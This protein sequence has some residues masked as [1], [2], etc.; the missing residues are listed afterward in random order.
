M[1]ASVIPPLEVIRGRFLTPIA[2]IPTQA[3]SDLNFS[4]REDT[5][6]LLILHLI[7]L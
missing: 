2:R 7:S 5:G 1:A 3:L 4:M 6:S